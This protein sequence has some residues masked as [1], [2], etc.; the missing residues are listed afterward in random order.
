[1]DTVER[2]AEE[3]AKTKKEAPLDA[4]VIEGQSLVDDP[5]GEEA[6]VL[7]AESEAPI[8]S[9]KPRTPENGRNSETSTY[10]EERFGEINFTQLERSGF[11]S[12]RHPVTRIAEEFRV[13]KRQLLSNALY[14]KPN[15]EASQRLMMVTSAQPGEGKTFTAVNLA[16]SI[17]AERNVHVLLIDGDFL[18]PNIFKLLGMRPQAGFLDVLQDSRLS[19][20]N[21]IWRTNVERLSLIHSGKFSAVANELLSSH[22]MQELVTEIASRYQDRIIIFDTPPMLAS[23]QPGMLA[24]YMN[25]I[26]F[27]VEAGKTS[28][29][30][31]QSALQLIP[32]NERVL[33]A[34]NKSKPLLDSGTF[35]SYYSYYGKT[36]EPNGV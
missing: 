22:R 14:A 17:A 15:S 33:M 24:Q 31:V 21:V 6:P 7:P 9:A 27:I 32:N 20:G 36:P 16:L 11:I 10:Q 28:H 13:L 4:R 26:L 23:S 3:L 35:G 29:R 5:A 34:L 8:L 30:A 1:M 19:I 12:P 18:H 2:A 25:Q